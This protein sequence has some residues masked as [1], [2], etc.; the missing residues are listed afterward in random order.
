MSFTIFH[1]APPTALLLGCLALGSCVPPAVAQDAPPPSRVKD[2]LQVLYEFGDAKPQGVSDRAGHKTP[3]DL[4]AADPAAIKPADGGVTIA[5]KTLIR[6]EKPATRLSEAIKKSGQ[7]T[8]EAWVRPVDTAHSG[9]ARIVTLSKNA[10]E[11]NFTLGQEKDKFEVRLRTTKTTTNG[12][13]SLLSQPNSV[14]T[15]WAHVAFTFGRSGQARLYVNGRLS[16]E[17]KV[18]GDL[19]NWD[20]GYPLAL[21]NE[22]SGDRQ[23]LGSLKLVAVYSRE[24]SASEVE[25]NFRAGTAP[26]PKREAL[27]AEQARARRFE[28]KIAPLLASHCL[29]CH[30]TATKKGGLDLSRKEGALAGGERGPVIVPGKS[31]ESRLWELVSADEMP[32]EREALSADEKKLLQSWLDDGA[33]WSLAAIDPAV[34]ALS[35]AVQKVYVQRLTVPEYIETV[36]STLG[37]DIAKEARELLP[38][39]LRADGFRNTAYNLN[40]DL[41]HVEAYAKLAEIIV[42]R[43]DVKALAK[44]H[45]NSRELT[46]E[47]VTKLI[48]PVGKRLLRGPVEPQE[49]S[50]YCGISTS[51]AAAGGN[52]DEAIGRILETM[53]QSPR[54]IYRIEGQRGSGTRPLSQ[55][56]LASRL[57]YILWGG[58]PDDELLAAA[59]KG[60][61]DK[62]AVA[63]QA[64]RML[65]DR[66]AISRSLQFISEWLNFDRLDS[67][68]P[69]RERF[70]QWD[71]ALAADMRQ[72]TLAFFEEIVWKQNR[73]LADLLNAQVT[74]VTPRLAKHYGLPLKDSAEGD[75]PVRVDLEPVPA[76]GGILTHGSVLTAGGDDA[77]MVTRGLFVMHELLRGVVRDPPPCVDTSPVPS[78]PGL[79]QRMVAEGRIANKSCSGCHSKFEPLAFALEKFD[80]LGSFHETDEFGNKLRED[81]NILVPG[82]GRSLPYKSSAELMDLLAASERV[83]ETITW[84]LTQFALGRPLAAEDAAAVAEIHQAAQKSGGTYASVM[85]A[86]VTSDL[87][88]RGRTEST[89]P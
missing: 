8:I 54:F 88:L 28:T 24:L 41:A 51:V 7:I 46:D 74:F 38:P 1:S 83:R 25:R 27:L 18:G 78:K 58:P 22:L 52:F 56:E 47:N 84:K 19:S 49:V 76:R 4:K 31:A 68:Q 57:S 12:I 75:K 13:P 80:G 23:W 70:P 64:Q 33:A 26:D 81:G 62:S 34:Y 82:E 85:T 53:L 61:L 43:I 63:A 71:A 10:N 42:Q 69:G 39:D 66:R 55:F 65:K 44:K 15:E 48:Q 3:I 67:L 59:E 30:D 79:T 86:I 40:V 6:S 11:R 73:P 35:S 16:A 9:P 77:S 37:V 32:Q 45:T 60:T 5:A 50:L 29:E 14:T 20:G 17:N 89:D 72:E 87:V 2:G 21:A 36:K